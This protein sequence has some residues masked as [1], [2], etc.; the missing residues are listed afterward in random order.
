[1]K[2]FITICI[3]CSLALAASAMAQQDQTKSKKKH[4]EAQAERQAPPQKQANHAQATHAARQVAE[5]HAAATHARVEQRNGAANLKANAHATQHR[6][7][8][9]AARKN[10]NTHTKNERANEHTQVTSARKANQGNQPA[11]RANARTA[12]KPD[13]QKIKA[14][15]A[16]FHA[17]A[18]PQQVRSVSYHQNYRINGSQHWQGEHY[19][20]FRSYHPE[21]HDR[22]WYHSHYNRIE[23]IG[24]GYYFWN[25]GY[26]YPAWGYSPTEAYYT[27]DGPI[28]TGT[29]AEPPDRVIANVQAALQDEG[30]YKG[31]VDGLLGPLT[32]QALTA[33]QSEHGLYTTA[34]IDEPTLD[35]LGM[36][37]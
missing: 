37:S 23:L 7:E 33:Y 10:A 24:G 36:G 13:V 11:N 28:Y 35:S 17:K 19:A 21:W 22:G 31:E 25:G 12:K 6:N 27:Y 32:Q 30:Y 15:H 29:V 9:N 2:K 20:A 34:A 26:W 3:S 5:P 4:Q 14:Q 1:M 16:N 8:A 18:R